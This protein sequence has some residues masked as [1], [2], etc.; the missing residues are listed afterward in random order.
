MSEVMSGV[1]ERAAAA[2]AYYQ[3]SPLAEFIE[4]QPGATLLCIVSVMCVALA[5]Y[6]MQWPNW[7]G[8]SSLQ[9]YSDWLRYGPVDQGNLLER[10]RWRKAKLEQQQ[11]HTHGSRRAKENA[12]RAKEAKDADVEQERMDAKR[13]AAKLEEER[14][15]RERDNARAKTVAALAEARAVEAEHR[16][17]LREAEASNTLTAARRAE[18]ERAA[19]EAEERYREAVARAAVAQ[20]LT[21][22]AYRQARREAAKR[23]AEY[24]QAARAREAAI[25]ALG[26]DDVA[27][28]GD[29]ERGRGGTCSRHLAIK[30]PIP[31]FRPLSPGRVAVAP[32]PEHHAI[33]VG[34][35]EHNLRA[36]QYSYA[37]QL[38][39][40]APSAAASAKRPPLVY[41]P[42]EPSPESQAAAMGGGTRLQERASKR[43]AAVLAR[44]KAAVA[45]ISPRLASPT[46]KRRDAKPS[47]AADAPAGARSPSPNKT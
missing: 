24:R 12:R 33:Q 43:A 34:G 26:Q 4:Q 23:V 3:G 6:Y 18:M 40:A 13:N 19:A 27:D 45:Y 30:P 9:D 41:P 35:S 32:S 38:M 14:R 36:Q 21:E 42:P 16:D 39:A 37:M 31:G 8:Y 46:K 11:Q 22:Q 17:S 15:R 47:G 28:G 5:R 2:W 44:G 20:A 25:W 10:E 7:H 1:S 29:V